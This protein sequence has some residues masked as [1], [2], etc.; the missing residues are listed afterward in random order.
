[1]KGRAGFKESSH[2]GR[3]G[4]RNEGGKRG[5]NLRTSVSGLRVKGHQIE[6]KRSRQAGT[7]LVKKKG[8]RS[9]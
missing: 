6:R 9:E 8:R 1:M 2:L 4:C 7:S 5:K 3:A